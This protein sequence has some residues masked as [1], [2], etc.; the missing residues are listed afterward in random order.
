MV[1]CRGKLIVLKCQNGETLRIE[2]DNPSG[3]PVVIS[4]MLTQNYIRKGCNA[5]LAYV[6]D[7]KVSESKNELVPAVCEYLNVF[8]EE[9]PGYH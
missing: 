9:L 4:A 5:Y 2:Y 3:L 7:T 8:L 1:N 6:L